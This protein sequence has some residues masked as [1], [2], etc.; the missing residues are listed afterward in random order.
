[1][2]GRKDL[3]DRR[4][5]KIDGA[6]LANTGPAPA[7]RQTSFT[8]LRAG[9]SGLNPAMI[10]RTSQILTSLAVDLDHV[11]RIWSVVATIGSIVAASLSS[12]LYQ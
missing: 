6:G 9:D 11:C 7:R 4:Y 2:P 1:M 3:Q 5:L 8:V 10:G 12:T